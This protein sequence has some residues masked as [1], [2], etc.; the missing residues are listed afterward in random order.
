MISWSRAEKSRG[1]YVEVCQ[2]P[3]HL[4]KR[5]LIVILDCYDYF[6]THKAERPMAVIAR[7][8]KAAKASG[9]FKRKGSAKQMECGRCGRVSIGSH[10]TVRDPRSSR[11]GEYI[12]DCGSEVDPLCSVWQTERV[13]FISEQKRRVRATSGRCYGG[14][15]KATSQTS[16]DGR[17]L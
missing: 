8:S 7:M 4:S 2:G 15:T 1:P 6:R 16:Q 11:F 12:W 17:S 3:H 9:T 10:N 13:L 5:K 14:R